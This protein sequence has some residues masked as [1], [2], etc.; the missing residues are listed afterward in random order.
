MD[1]IAALIGLGTYAASV[2]GEYVSMTESQKD[3]AYQKDLLNMQLTDL[4]EEYANTQKDLA[5]SN[6]SSMDTLNS[7]IST[8]RTSQLQEAR[9]SA[10][11]NVASDAEAWETLAQTI[12]SANQTRG[13]TV[14]SAATSGFRN[15]GTQAA[16]VNTT[17]QQLDRTVGVAESTTRLTTTARFLQARAAYVTAE[18]QISAYELAIENQKASY[19]QS[20]ASAKTSYTNQKELL[21]KERNYYSDQEQY[22]STHKWWMM[23]LPGAGQFMTDTYNASKG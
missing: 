5:L 4:E 13:T 2:A 11:S 3:A 21:T 6:D 10:I 9:A 17:N 16:I 7:N 22:L 23:W 1:W 15:S 14:A 12:A 20:L 18:G 19:Q 8:T